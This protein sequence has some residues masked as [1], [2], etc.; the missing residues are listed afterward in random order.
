M[1]KQKLLWISVVLA[2]LAGVAWFAMSREPAPDTRYVGAYRFEEDGTL[3]VIGP[4]SL[5]DLRFKKMN[6]ET[7]ALWPTDTADAYEGGTGWSE[8]EPVTNRVRFERDAGGR[9]IGLTWHHDGNDGSWQRRAWRLPLREEFVT[10][11]SGDLTLRAKLILPEGNGPFPVMVPVHGS[12]DYSAVHH[13]SDPYMFAAH[14]IAAFIYDKRGT[15]GSEGKFTANF[16]VLSDDTVAA[17][18]YLRQR[19]DIDGDDIHLAG[20]S[21][22]GWIAPLAALKDGNIRSIFVGMRSPPS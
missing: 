2:L 18:R 7:G 20:Y 12:E 21:Q 3:L 1:R 5:T 17:V 11:R 16:H 9:L 22:G 6:G 13:Y 19:P 10:F 14:G 8:R 4:R 15:G